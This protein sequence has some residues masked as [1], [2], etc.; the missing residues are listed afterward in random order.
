MLD[1]D[2]KK[3]A[4]EALEQA[5]GK[6]EI[7]LARDPKLALAPASM[8]STTYD[9]FS[10]VA[11]INVVRERAEDALEDGRLQ[12]ARRLIRGLASE[13][14]ISVMN[15]PLATYP[16]AIKMAVSS[17]DAGK[18]KEAK[19]ILQAALST[20]VVTDTV[21]P[22]PVV[23]AEY[24][25]KHAETLAGKAERSDGENKLLSGFLHSARKE[26][27]LAE[28]LGYSSKKNFEEL[29]EQIDEIEEKTEGGKTGKGFFAK[30]KNFLKDVMETSQS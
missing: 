13:T 18:V 4:L 8:S 12:E 26:L 29:Y 6:L 7:I 21:I 15:I 16:K 19:V 27:E 10:S 28:A 17:I 2:K 23:R 30:I 5:T 22:L 11:A 24:N 14:V 9:V 3:E 20:L 1:E 25:L